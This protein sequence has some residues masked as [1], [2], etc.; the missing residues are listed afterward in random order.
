VALVGWM[1][2][3][4]S[5]SALKKY[6]VYIEFDPG[7]AAE[8]AAF[9]I[10]QGGWFLLFFVLS[11]GAVALVM[12]GCCA[13]KRAKFGLLLL[14]GVLVLDLGRAHQPW[15]IHW[16]WQQKYAT[17]PVLDKLRTQAHEQRVVGLPPWIPGAFQLADQARGLEQYLDQLYRIEWAQH[18]FLY[19]NIQSLDVIQ[20]PRPPEDMVAY[21]SA[22]GVR[23]GETLRLQTRQWELSNTRYILALAGFV[24]LFNQQFDPE[25]KRF[26]VAETF[27]IGPKSGV[28]QITKLEEL[29]AEFSPNAPYALIEFTGALPRAKLYHN[30]Q[31]VTNEQTA[32]QTLASAAFDPAQTVLVAENSVGAPSVATNLSKG[33]AEIKRYSPK[34]ITIAATAPAPAILLL[35][36]RFTPNWKVIVDGQPAPLLKCNY[37]M[38]GVQLSP[39]THTVEFVFQPAVTA[40][41]VSLAAIAVAILLLTVLLLARSRSQTAAPRQ[42]NL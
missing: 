10:R 5:A 12:S 27:N 35:N 15:I 42:P 26:R 22:L 32:L 2:Y 30:W 29:T 19:Y 25:Q 39:G 28:T 4:S 3:N 17:N 38:R 34:R 24:D 7:S 8:I 31:V 37:L 41:R 6:L 40:L 21:N 16:D 36:E 11:L 14:G 9:S 1:I 33:T 18:H 20:M 13:G 23:S